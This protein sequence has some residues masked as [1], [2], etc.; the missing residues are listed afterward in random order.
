[1]NAAMKRHGLSLPTPGVTTWGDAKRA[2][3]TH[4]EG[5]VMILLGAVR[6]SFGPET[7]AVEGAVIRSFL[8]RRSVRDPA[9]AQCNDARAR[10]ASRALCAR[11][12]DMKA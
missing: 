3:F 4:R 8:A 10:S 11:S 12:A 7:A 2:K 5:E 1:M 9:R 6:N